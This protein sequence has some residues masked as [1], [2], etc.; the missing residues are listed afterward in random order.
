MNAC[1]AEPLPELSLRAHAADARRAASWLESVCRE[2]A[3]PAEQIA[4][5]DIC[6]NEVLANVI[7]HGGAA[8]AASPLG[9]SFD[10]RRDPGSC[11]VLVTVAAAGAAFDPLAA[12]PRLPATTLADAEPGGLGLVLIRRFAD[13][14]NYLYAEG[15]NR[16]TFGV[17]WP[18]SS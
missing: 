6:L 17:R 7:D 18:G 12:P 3:V 9:L 14:L 11:E 8:A 4:R 13:S 10:L 5:L 2:R 15:R 1:A 16:L